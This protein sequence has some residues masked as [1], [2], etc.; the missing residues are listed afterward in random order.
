MRNRIVSATNTLTSDEP[1]PAREPDVQALHELLP[2]RRHEA[3]HHQQRKDDGARRAS[4]VGDLAGSLGHDGRRTGQ[5]DRD[6]HGDGDEQPGE[7]GAPDGQP[8][9]G[10][11][12]LG[13]GS[14]AASRQNA[15]K[16][17]DAPA[18]RLDPLTSRRGERPR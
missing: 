2:C 4:G 15:G 8:E 7:D 9:L 14:S 17:N 3:G 5:R 10:G 11:D 6:R 13:A 18:S 1:L 16:P 12:E